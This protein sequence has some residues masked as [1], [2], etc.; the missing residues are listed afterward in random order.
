MF[1]SPPPLDDTLK[2]KI[3]PSFLNRTAK[4]KQTKVLKK[5]LQNQASLSKLRSSFRI[6]FFFSSPASIKFLID[7]NWMQL[8]ELL[9]F[10]E[11]RVSNAFLSLE[12][13]KLGWDIYLSFHAEN[14]L[15]FQFLCPKAFFQLK[16]VFPKLKIIIISI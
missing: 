10:L 16:Y 11:R 7:I 1:F 3:L 2:M 8:V 15:R 4:N 14:A 9:C 12:M 13:G 6:Q 5:L